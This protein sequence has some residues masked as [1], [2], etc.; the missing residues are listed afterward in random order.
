MSAAQIKAG[1]QGATQAE[2]DARKPFDNK[3][4]RELNQ[5]AVCKPVEGEVIPAAPAKPS[6][7]QAGIPR[8]ASDA[9]YTDTIRE[10]HRIG[11]SAVTYANGAVS[12]HA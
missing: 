9:A 3:V 2:L 11:K 6:A 4:D 10:T 5:V 8:D 7:N 12:E 1:D